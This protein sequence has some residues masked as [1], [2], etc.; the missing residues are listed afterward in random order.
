[1]PALLIWT[2]TRDN[3]LIALR[4]EGRSWNSIAALLGLSRWAAIQ[5][6]QVVGAQKPESIPAMRG[7]RITGREPLPA[8]HPVSWAVL[9]AGTLLAG[10]EYPYPPLMPCEERDVM[11]APPVEVAQVD[12]PLLEW[13]A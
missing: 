5:R 1:M 6:G 8:G 3:L 2:E 11:A 7:T 4:A 10:Q 13:A 9:T 12:A